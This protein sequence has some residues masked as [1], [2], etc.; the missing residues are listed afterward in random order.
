MCYYMK[1]ETKKTGMQCAKRIGFVI[2]L[3]VKAVS[4]DEYSRRLANSVIDATRIR[5]NRILETKKQNTFKRGAKSKVL[6][7]YVIQSEAY[8]VNKT[9]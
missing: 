5:P 6:V 2:R 7:L 9:L 4:T 3:Y 8:T 1:L